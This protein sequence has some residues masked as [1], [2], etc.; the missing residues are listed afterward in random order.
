[1]QLSH[2]KQK[3]LFSLSFSSKRFLNLASSVEVLEGLGGTGG[4]GLL[5]L[6]DPDTGLYKLLTSLFNKLVSFGGALTSKYF[7]L[8]LSSPSGLPTALRR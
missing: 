7:L 8:G 5:T 6:T 1:M 4:H 2:T 3:Q